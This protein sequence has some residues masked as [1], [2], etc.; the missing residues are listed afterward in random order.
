L[1]VGTRGADPSNNYALS[2]Y[3]SYEYLETSATPGKNGLNV[4]GLAKNI[5]AGGNAATSQFDPTKIIIGAEGRI[6]ASSEKLD[7]LFLDSS[8]D[9]QLFLLCDS[10]V[11][12]ISPETSASNVYQLATDQNPLCV[13]SIGGGSGTGAGG[14]GD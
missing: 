14:T 5:A 4:Y 13:A 9:A 7:I 6:G 8:K 10:T 2:R 3:A 12:D 1:I 11:S